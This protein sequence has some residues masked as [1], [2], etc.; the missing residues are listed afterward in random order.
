MF[1][2]EDR[3]SAARQRHLGGWHIGSVKDENEAIRIMH[4]AIDEGMTFFDNAWDYHEGRSSS[5][6][7]TTNASTD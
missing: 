3:D 7:R 5:T 6:G 1:A 2:L 4:T